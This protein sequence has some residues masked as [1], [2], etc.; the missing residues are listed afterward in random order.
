MNQF[1]SS[2]TGTRSHISIAC[3]GGRSPGRT[4]RPASGIPAAIF[5]AAKDAARAQLRFAF[6]QRPE[7]LTEAPARPSRV[8]QG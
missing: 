8:A 5:Y 6:R 3:H 7:V 1:N 4:S 2:H